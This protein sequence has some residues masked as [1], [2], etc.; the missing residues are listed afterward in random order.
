MARQLRVRLFVE[1]GPLVGRRSQPRPHRAV[2]RWGERPSSH[3]DL[4]GI[5]LSRR[6]PRKPPTNMPVVSSTWMTW[7]SSGRP[8]E[9]AQVRSAGSGGRAGGRGWVGEGG[10]GLSCGE[11]MVTCL[12][13]P[14]VPVHPVGNC[15]PAEDGEA[16]DAEVS[17]RVHVGVLQTGDAHGGDDAKHDQEHAS[18]HRLGDGGE[19]SADLPENPQDEQHTACGDHHHP[20]PH[21]GTA[22]KERAAT[23][24]GG[25][26]TAAAAAGPPHGGRQDRQGAG[27][28]WAREM[29]CS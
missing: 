14:G 20:A 21:L 5:V 16:K 24:G 6:K 15:E 19:R 2:S 9:A 27:K 13:H 7:S 1:T 18:D 3:W 29:G 4:P 17:L 10:E 26:D 12:E 23:S 25:R 8:A 22:W 28:G 11:R